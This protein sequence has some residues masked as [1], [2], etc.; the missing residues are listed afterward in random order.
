MEKRA[1]EPAQRVSWRDFLS[2]QGLLIALIIVAAIFSLLSP[3]FL[4]I[5]NILN[6]ALALAITLMLSSGETVAIICGLTDL[7]IASN[8]AFSSVV[9]ALLLSANVHFLLAIAVALASGAAIGYINGFATTR[10]KVNPLITTLGTLATFRGLAFIISDGKSIGVD[11]SHFESIGKDSLLGIPIPFIAA[12]VMCL[13]IYYILDWT[14]FGRRVRAVGGNS[15]IAELFGINTNRIKISAFIISG[16]TAAIAGIFT[17][18]RMKSGA[19]IAALGQELPVI[20]AVILGG[21]S[22]SGGIGNIWGTVLG[23]L[24]LSTLS[25]GFTLTYV[26][27]F[28]QQVVRGIILIGAVSLDIMRREKRRY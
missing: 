17:T 3:Y 6:I 27:S 9:M 22:I 20:T 19:P 23:V 25:N 24:F 16:L 21:A 10:L 26:S 7:S 12:L 14:V 13:L 18:A 15:D 5:K 4:T 2:R 8:L 1:A 11:N 28:W